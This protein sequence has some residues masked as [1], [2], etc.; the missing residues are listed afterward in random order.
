M[1]SVEWFNPDKYSQFV[2][3]QRKSLLTILLLKKEMRTISAQHGIGRST[4]ADQPNVVRQLFLT[5]LE[6]LAKEGRTTPTMWE[7]HNLNVALGSIAFKDFVKAEHALI[8]F[9]RLPSP[10]DITHLPAKERCLST[11]EINTAF[12]RVKS[13]L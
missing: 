12:D 7:E 11:E 6:C 10:A 2:L 3:P 8:E 5:A 13:N 9:S 1:V 4:M